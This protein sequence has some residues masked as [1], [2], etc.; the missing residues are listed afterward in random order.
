MFRSTRTGTVFVAATGAQQI[1]QTETDF[2]CDGM[3]D[4]VEIQAAVD[5]LPSGGGMV[6]L[7]E[8]TFTLAAT[9]SRSIANVTILGM[10]MS[11]RLVNNASTKL[12]SDGGQAGWAFL[13][14]DV[15]AGDVTAS[16]TGNVTDY[17][18]DGT[19]QGGGGSQLT[20]E[21][22]QD[23]AGN[24]IVTGGT[25]TGIAITYDDPN[26]D[27]DYV[28]DHDT[29]A[30][31]EA[32]E[33]FPNDGAFPT[34]WS[35]T[36]ITGAELEDLSDGGETSIHS[37]AG[38]G[39]LTTEEVEDIAG[40]LVASGGTKTGIAITYQDSTDD[41]DFVVDHDTSA[42]F[43]QGEHFTM[44]DEDDLTTDSN[45]QA[46]TQQSVKAYIDASGKVAGFETFT[47]VIDA[48]ASNDNG[49]TVTLAGGS[50]YILYQVIQT[51][52]TA[53]DSAGGNFSIYVTSGTYNE[54]LNF[55][56]TINAAVDL[57][58]SGQDSVIIGPTGAGSDDGLTNADA[59]STL[60]I[61]NLT[62]RGQD[63]GSS[64]FATVKGI[65]NFTNVTFNDE[66][67]MDNAGGKYIGC[68]FQGGYNT[69]ASVTPRDVRFLD[70]VFLTTNCVWT[71]VID[72]HYFI[73]C[74]WEDGVNIVI[75]AEC[76]D[77]YF[78]GC[79]FGT[80]N[81][82]GGTTKFSYNAGS[83]LLDVTFVSCEFP[84]P[85]STNGIIYVQACL[86]D[87]VM[88]II[89]CTFRQEGSET[90][91]YIKSD[92]TNLSVTANGNLFRAGDEYPIF[93]GSFE[94]SVFGPNHPSDYDIDIDAGSNNVYYGSKTS[95]TGE[96]GTK[97]IFDIVAHDTT[98]TGTNLTELTDASETTLH[99]HA[100]GGGDVTGDTASIDTEI[101][102]WNGTTGKI[103]ESPNTENSAVS[104]TL[105]SGSL[106]LYDASN[107]GNPFIRMGSSATNFYQINAA[108]DSGAQ[109]LDYL[110]ITTDS[111][112]A[113]ADKGEIRFVVD[114]VP[115]FTIN[116][117]GVKLEATGGLIDI[118]SE[119]KF[120]ERA[121]HISTPTD[122]FGYLWVKN[123]TPSVLI[124]TDDAGTDVD[125]VAA[126]S[127]DVSAT[128]SPL[129]NEIAVFTNG[130]TID[131]D[132]TFT[133]NG[134]TLAITGALIID[135]ITL[136]STTISSSTT[137]TLSAPSGLVIGAADDHTTQIGSI[138][139]ARHPVTI[140]TNGDVV[141]PTDVRFRVSA[142]SGTADDLN[143]IGAGLVNGQI[144]Y[145]Y[146]DDGD[147]IT[148]KHLTAGGSTGKLLAINGE[149]DYILSEDWHWVIAIWDST[150]DQWEVMVPG[151]GGNVTGDTASIEN[152]LVR[153]N[154]TGGKTIESPN[155]DNNSVTAT[156]SNNVD[157]TLYDATN[158]GNPVFSFGS[159]GTNKLAITA[160]Y[161]S[162]LQTLDYI[163]FETTTA[164][165]TAD[166][167]EFRFTVDSVLQAT[168]DDGGL[169]IKVSGAIGFGAIDVLSDSSGTTTLQN[170]DVVDATTANSIEAVVSHTD[171]QNK[172]IVGHDTTA[173]GTNLTELTDASETTLHSHAAGSGDVT[174]DT[175]SIDLE[176]VR[177]NGTTGKII[178][179]PGTEN[180]AV[181]FN[182]NN[183]GGL[184]LFSNANDADPFFRMG[185]DSPDD[186]IIQTRY[187]SGT[188]NLEY[189]TFKTTSTSGTA[190]FGEIRFSVDN[191][192]IAT[193]D[194]GGIEIKASG[195]LSFGAIDI[196]TDSAGTTTLSNIDVIDSTTG[197][198]IEADVVHDN[199][200]SI[201]ANDHIDWTSTA[202]NFST[203]GTVA[204]GNLT[205]TGTITIGA[206]E[207]SETELEIL[208]GAT[209]TTTELNIIDGS[210]SATGT[211]LVDADRMVINDGGVMVQVAL[212]DLKTYMPADVVGDT[213]SVDKE[214]VRFNGTGG[215][216]IESPNTDVATTTATL[217]DSGDLTL[218]DATNNGNIFIRFGAAASNDL[219]IQTVY[220]SDS[221]FIDYVDF[222]VDTSSSDAD[223]GE[224][225]FSVDGTL[226]LTIDDGGIEIRASGS[227]SFGAITI[228]SD[229]TGTTTLQNIDVIDSTTGAAIEADIVHDNL[230]SVPANDHID[231][232]G[233]T[234]TAGVGLSGGGS[235][236][237]GIT[238]TVDLNELGTE[239]TIDAGVDF[240]AMVDATDSGS[241][242]ILAEDIP[243]GYDTETT[244]VGTDFVNMIDVT[245]NNAGKIT[246][247]NF[248]TSIDS[249]ILHDNLGSIPAN[250][251]I[252]WTAASSNFA[253][254][255]TI[256]GSSGIVNFVAA[257]RVKLTA[258]GVTGESEIMIDVTPP[259][260]L[261]DDTLVW[262][263]NVSQM[264]AV[265]LA[266][267]EMPGA[268]EDGHTVN[269]NDTNKEFELVAAVA[270][271]GD[272]VGDTASVDKEL[273]RFN[274]TTGKIIESPNT[275]N[276]N[277]TTTLSDNADLVLFDATNNSS[278]SFSLGS[279]VAEA[280]T[281]TAFF[282]SGAQT[283]EY[284][285]FETL[286]ESG[287]ADHGEFRFN[288][289]GTLKF[290]I[291]DGGIE[292]VAS[293]SLSFG[294]ITILSDSA[295]T[296]SLSNIDAIDTTTGEAIEADIAHDNI[297][298]GTVVSHDTDTTGA[299]LTELADGSTTTLHN[300]AASGA[301]AALDN[302]SSVQI[303]TTLVS[304][305]DITDDLGT[306]DVRWKD[307][308][309]ETISSGLTATDVLKLR[310]RD[311]DG[312]VYVDVFT[313]TS[314]D[315]VTA[316][317]NALV[318][319]G[320][321]AILDAASTVS[322]LT[323]VG[324]ITT[325]TWDATT[326]AVAAGG[327][328]IETATDG[329]VLIGA[330][331]GAFEVTDA[332][333]VGSDTLADEF[334]QAKGAGNNPDYKGIEQTVSIT[335][336]NPAADDNITLRHFNHGATIQ[337]V[338][339][340][341]I[342]GTSVAFNLYMDA[343]RTTESTDVFTSD[344]VITA[345]TAMTRDTPNVAAIAADDILFIDLSA[346]VGSP[347]EFHVTV[348]YTTT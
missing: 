291:D 187:Q 22:V 170:I 234:V 107:N 128:G 238:L 195:S 18:I 20:T 12:I 86:A 34:T 311:V 281:L 225:R 271:G 81:Q 180:S 221:Q 229:S 342:G 242:K 330:T 126:G 56:T 202:S 168:I 141:T 317:L 140:D 179:S 138:S 299:E 50:T 7:S 183:N 94:N 139:H 295:G 279:A 116:D 63:S 189:L 74:H 133:W 70:C 285:E 292:I 79:N 109:T 153:F 252:D 84:S 277:V 137:L 289:D 2:L 313:I 185:A 267:A 348:R 334:L 263:G 15:D 192:L 241:Q 76:D 123:D 224:Y 64:A 156:L 303:N 265:G 308:W 340:I 198:A 332:G 262:W 191:T 119:I 194:D 307:T 173:T 319:I 258:Q 203:S 134:S 40:A 297:T 112:N 42:N 122:T 148:L 253:T 52:I 208:D 157:L 121:D 236:E 163:L 32:K 151:S 215:K 284:A 136:N 82:A 96:V 254:S 223:A 80:G 118:V 293:G 33:H 321:N 244:M 325:G 8:G 201:P 337:E 206:A 150:G 326:V 282:A 240:I 6:V 266:S 318:T 220:K 155:T 184:T 71:D 77:I 127:G 135:S 65:V 49:Q 146:P 314:N 212:S 25:K 99:S 61:S 211:T 72:E 147:D 216:T 335:I 237:S 145:I 182:L 57:V 315:T 275:D 9:I 29:A 347:T 91:P 88:K 270:G 66:V 338:H 114:T 324:T 280:L 213:A 160:A 17:W 78:V 97:K 272:V 159:S 166:D 149:A 296:T 165:A 104:A 331:T 31:F 103:I 304:D 175:A 235:I 162:G 101:V 248:A 246:L 85:D 152:E 117:A 305:T 178:E 207:I 232:T 67:R 30:N 54:T 73:G 177:W 46:A 233:V 47:Y 329:G 59:G 69:G 274:S 306:G 129:N 51:A 230:Q 161:N 132:S 250:D 322:I 290:T 193:I 278:P 44:L 257:S 346:V 38:G 239:T 143:E 214:L 343:T 36:G 205:V 23:I 174:G 158:D 144:I 19:R 10:G 83:S 310:A 345:G 172:T 113:A 39:Q 327:T 323:D 227:L 222:T 14:F 95:L 320:G 26:N 245:D 190:D 35:D 269:Y 5:S 268:S 3:A 75:T 276:S 89:G 255:G 256:T 130:T 154:G 124:F 167:G 196:L 68:I 92:N 87:S 300:H 176:I 226:Q 102:T 341:C 218:Y 228:L 98:A 261:V 41:M 294:A 264:T 48:N 333:A 120:T 344:P 259:A 204:T 24:L 186:V 125:L 164:S 171:L 43:T 209:V 188:T 181:S 58:G 45:T 27:M 28:V 100:A 62:L 309:F 115:K 288:V 4:D 93:K 336:E 287:T 53:G 110:S 286:T 60:N 283:I 111:S 210:T 11:T 251:H 302:L 37:H 231:H 260:A 169:E 16:G 55:P 199:L 249:V 219:A 247:A 90:N 197:A 312:S 108:F 328:G 21:E 273:V 298:S 339:S 13:E 105:S 217:T 131:S 142:F 106:V 316:D 301:T 243:F 200:Q 1:S